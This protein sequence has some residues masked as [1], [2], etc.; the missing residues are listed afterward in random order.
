MCFWSLCN[1][2]RKELLKTY[3]RPKNTTKALGDGFAE[4]K[5]LES[6]QKTNKL[7]IDTTKGI[8]EA[9]NWTGSRRSNS[10]RKKDCDIK[11]R[12]EPNTCQ[13]CGEV[14]EPHKWAE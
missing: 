4:T 1:P 2:I 8:G 9:V 5:S 7:I 6:A 3:L 13:W 11:L 14:R 10:F 12:R